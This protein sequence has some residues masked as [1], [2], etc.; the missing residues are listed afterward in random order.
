MEQGSGN[1][2]PVQ[3][4]PTCGSL[5]DEN[6]CFAVDFPSI[7]ACEY[8]LFR[9]VQTIYI[10]IY[11]YTYSYIYIY[12]NIIYLDISG[13]LE[14]MSQSIPQQFI[15]WSPAISQP[16][17]L[18]NPVLL[19]SPQN[20]QKYGEISLW[21]PAK[22]GC[23]MTGWWLS[24]P[25]EKCDFVR[26]LEKYMEK[27]SKPPTRYFDWWSNHHLV[28]FGQV[29]LSTSLLM[30]SLWICVG[31][32][33]WYLLRTQVIASCPFRSWNSWCQEVLGWPPT[34]VDTG[35]HSIA[36]HPNVVIMGIDDW[37]IENMDTIGLFWDLRIY[38][39]YVPSGKLT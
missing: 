17:R 20:P 28:F 10:Y 11:I 2:K 5:V 36:D 38:S 23:N 18:L 29:K 14:I 21:T 3:K 27:C 26:Q 33:N 8:C 16:Y 24:H 39:A 31:H 7:H 9:L 37:T 25:S 1:R 12:I 30:K 32:Y 4:N 13:Y 19:D 22:Y 6:H 34:A 15:I 35:C